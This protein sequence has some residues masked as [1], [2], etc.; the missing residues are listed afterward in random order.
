M[1]NQATL[2]L[3]RLSQGYS[4]KEHFSYVCVF[5]EHQYRIRLEAVEPMSKEK[6]IELLVV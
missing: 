6:T 1:L 5:I 3:L 2:P 4:R